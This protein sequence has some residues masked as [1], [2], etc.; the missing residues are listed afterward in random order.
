[1]RGLVAAWLGACTGTGGTPSTEPTGTDTVPP[2]PA[3]TMCG[4]QQCDDGE[5]TDLCPWDC[6][7]YIVEE[8][9]SSGAACDRVKTGFVPL[10]DLGPGSYLGRATGGLYPGGSNIRPD[11]HTAEGVVRAGRVAPI[12]GRICVM[13]VGMSNTA[14]KWT[15]FTSEVAPSLPDL[16][17]A[18]TL[19][20]GAVGSNP[21]DTTADP[22]HRV[23]GTIE[24]QLGS[25]GCSLDTVQVAWIL[26][27]ERGP[28]GSFEAARDVFTEDLLATVLNLADRAPA[29]QLVYLSS[30]VYGGYGTRNNNPEPYA[31]QGGF[32]V[33]ALVA[34]QIEGSE[35]RLAL[36][37][38]APWLSWGPYLWADGEAGRQDGLT[39]ECEDF[40]DSDG[41]HPGRGSRAKVA[42]QLAGFFTTDPTTTPWFLAP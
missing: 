26:H 19:A 34:G 24:Q 14:Q 7:P 9:G 31:H 5:D 37:A 39:Y 11:A 4:N 27:A 30:R 15:Y 10:T 2:E 21:V 40:S 25:V 22:D 28:S 42:E 3:V 35:P 23:W 6:V 13:S 8:R 41:I 16:N 36:S 33:Q 1:M 29:L 18:V 17:P 20:Q 12:E 38:G 32:A